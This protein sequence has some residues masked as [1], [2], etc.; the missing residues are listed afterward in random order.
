MR[1]VE[2]RDDLVAAW[3]PPGAER[4][5]PV[6]DA[7]REIRIPRGDW[8]LGPLVTRV[9]SLVLLRPGSHHSLW[10][11]WDGDRFDHWYVNFEEPLGRT[12]FG[13]DIKDWKLDLV[14]DADGTR[15]WKDE[16]EL[17]EAARLGIVDADT[18]WAEAERVVADPPWPTGWED[19][20]PDPSWPVPRFPPGWDVV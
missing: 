4:Y 17:E 13:F 14:V 10:L 18:V 9:P 2:A 20:R 15:R 16:D 5:V 19:W 8:T 1:V 7:G 11:F 3:T 12:S 6:D